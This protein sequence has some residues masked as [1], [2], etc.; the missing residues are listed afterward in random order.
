MLVDLRKQSSYAMF[1]GGEIVR[2]RD[3]NLAQCERKYSLHNSNK[4]QEDGEMD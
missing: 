1:N 4:A 3:R 2:V